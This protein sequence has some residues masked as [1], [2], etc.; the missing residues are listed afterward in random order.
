MAKDKILVVEDDADFAML[1]VEALIGAG[2]EADL[3]ETLAGAQHKPLADYDAIV[4][5]YNL[6][7]GTGMPVLEKVAD[8]VTT[9]VVVVTAETAV[10]PVVEALKAGAATWLVKTA[11]SL[12]VLPVVLR[13][14]ID[15]RREKADAER[16][17]AKAEES[18]RQSEARYRLLVSNVSDIIIQMDPRGVITFVTPSMKQVLGRDEATVVGTSFESITTRPSYERAMGVLQERLAAGAKPPYYPIVLE[19]DLV[20]ADGTPCACEV[21]AVFVRDDDG[22]P[23]SVVSVVRDITERKAVAEALH[24]NENEIE[25]LALEVAQLR[26]DVRRRYALDSVIGRDP[27][28]Q[29]IFQTVV[30]VGRTNA[31]VLVQG[32]TGTGKELVAKAIHYNSARR[33]HP[34]VKVD[35]GALAENL[36]ESELFGHVK[37]AF[38]GAVSDKRG[39]FEMASGGTIFL[40]EIHNL[41]MPLQAKLLRIVQ[42][43]TYEKVGGS[44]TQTAD[45]RIVAATNENLKRLVDD[46]T[47]RIDLY[48]RLNVIPVVIPPLRERTADIPLL[49]ASFVKR[50]ADRHGKPVKDV[51]EEALEKLAGYEWPGNVREL[52]NIIEQAVVFCP[53]ESLSAA[54]IHLPDAALPVEG[55]PGSG[56]ETQTLRKA[57]EDPERRLIVDALRKTDGNRKRAAEVLGIS[58]SALY[59]K[60]RRYGIINKA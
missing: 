60:L 54:D 47:F 25:A 56:G 3:A 26:S 34:F 55:G 24:R 49:A 23:Q 33:D 38:T 59:E 7:D 14:T 31:T 45:V 28:M 30:E 2:F 42:D 53:G 29:A 52:E 9:P 27:K 16:A 6:P 18:L 17:R 50:F 10:E 39:R 40:D 15:E 43:G 8:D 36:L 35:C 13:Q 44:E 41:S 22:T 21:H 58:R 46:K 48:Y 4:L 11:D 19:L 32:E 57:L 1:E 20:R 37:G 12:S 5:D 51:S